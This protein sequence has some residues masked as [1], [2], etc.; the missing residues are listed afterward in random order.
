MTC[1]IETDDSGRYVIFTDRP[2]VARA[3]PRRVASPGLN[4]DHC[5]I[6]LGDGQVFTSAQP[7]DRLSPAEVEMIEY[8]LREKGADITPDIFA[9]ELRA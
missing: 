1:K 5:Y 7:L 3:G 9:G 8:F 6:R 4:A 2:D